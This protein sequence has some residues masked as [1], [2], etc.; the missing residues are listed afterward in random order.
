MSDQARLPASTIVASIAYQTFTRA[1]TSVFE[2]NNAKR[3]SRGVSEAA[4]QGLEPQLP[5]SPAR[6][7][8][9]PVR[10]PDAALMLGSARGGSP[11]VPVRTCEKL[12]TQETRLL[13]PRRSKPN[14]GGRSDAGAAYNAAA[15]SA[16]ERGGPPTANRHG[17]VARR[18]QSRLLSEATGGRPQQR[19]RCRRAS[20]S[21]SASAREACRTHPLVDGMALHQDSLRALRDG[22][23]AEC[24]FEIVELGEPAQDDVD[25][26]LPIQ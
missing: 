8:T 5:D 26:A 17:L 13:A 1:V 20:G 19:R 9:V 24:A 11:C 3:P 12:A 25:R 16:A 4:G 10:C 22:A 18:Q 14:A 6:M 15:I 2:T 21:S 7:P 23:A